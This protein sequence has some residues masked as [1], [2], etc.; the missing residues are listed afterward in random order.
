MD[1]HYKIKPLIIILPNTI[2]YIKIL[3]VKLN[4]CIFW[5][6]I[7]IYWQCVMAFAIKSVILWKKNLI[8][9]PSAIKNF[10][11]PKEESYGDEATNFHDK[12]TA[13]VGSNYI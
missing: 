13:K 10:R 7:M 3:M 8:A 2:A 11:K 6:K 1:D 9:K 5:T 4:G 12:E